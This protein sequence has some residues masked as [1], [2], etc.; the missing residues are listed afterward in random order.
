MTVDPA[1]SISTVTPAIGE[2]GQT[3][4]VAVTGVFSNFLQDSTVASFSA[5]ITVNSTTVTSATQAT[6]NITIAGNAGG[7]ARSVTMTTGVEVA[8]LTNG[9]TVQIPVLSVSP[10]SGSQ[11][12]QSLSVLITGQFTHFAQGDEHGQRYADP[13]SLSRKIE[14]LTIVGAGKTH[15]RDMKCIPARS[16]KQGRRIGRQSMIQQKSFHAAPWT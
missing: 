2:P 14:N 11:G 3:L 7:G 13:V 5:G 1:A 4:S 8:T 6:V 10:N 12:Q 16:A 9:F 15:F